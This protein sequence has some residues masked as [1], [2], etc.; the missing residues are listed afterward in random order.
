MGV[1]WMDGAT[2]YKM[3]IEAEAAL[4]KRI[5]VSANGGLA[6]FDSKASPYLGATLKYKFN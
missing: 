4:G 1:D 6:V 3:F 2:A 5:K